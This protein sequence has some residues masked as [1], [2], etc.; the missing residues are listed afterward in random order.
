MDASRLS[1]ATCLASLA[2]LVGCTDP[3]RKLVDA[4]HEIHEGG[5]L[6]LMTPGT[7]E[8]ALAARKLPELSEIRT[9]PVG[10]ASVEFLSHLGSISTIKEF[11]A[12]NGMSKEA[13]AHLSQFPNI[14]T[15]TFWGRSTPLTTLPALLK[16]RVL[17]CEETELGLDDI[18]A[19]SRCRNL[20]EFRCDCDLTPE[21]IQLLKEMPKLERIYSGNF[22]TGW[23]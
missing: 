4:G 16:L 23:K 9:L 12:H 11:G 22:K 6:S 19:V 5:C 15:L 21:S 17:Y 18:E 20:E 3:T 7:K 13:V 1:V 14:E 2:L 10:G 8:D